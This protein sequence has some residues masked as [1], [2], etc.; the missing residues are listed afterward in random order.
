MHTA[1]L[2]DALLVL[3]HETIVR[4]NSIESIVLP[5]ALP[6]ADGNGAERKEEQTA[7]APSS[8]KLD[9]DLV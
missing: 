7:G 5:L 3:G 8:G 6:V 4:P 1:L 9:L 2:S